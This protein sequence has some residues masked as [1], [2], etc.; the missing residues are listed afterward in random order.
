MTESDVDMERK[1]GYC[2]LREVL[3]V[4]HANGPIFRSKTTNV[5]HNSFESITLHNHLNQK[6]ESAL[7][8]RP[9]HETAFI[10]PDPSTKK[11]RAMGCR[12]IY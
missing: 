2:N 6:Q 5:R 10:V 11:A 3:F 7:I 8:G 1:H 4:A 9:A 12:S